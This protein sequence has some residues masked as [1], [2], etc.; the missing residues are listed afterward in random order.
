MNIL[1][2]I[3]TNNLYAISLYSRQIAGTIVLFIIA[4]YLSIYDYGLFTS[5]KSIITFCFMFANMEYSNYI[6]VSSQAN[7]KEV[8]LKIA[9]FLVNAIL[10]GFFIAFF[11]YFFKLENHLLFTLIIIRTFFDSIFFGLILPYFQATK[12][13]NN[14]AKINIIYSFCISLIAIISYIFKLSLVKFLLLNIGLGII[15]FIQCSYFAK[16]NYLLVFTYIKRFIRMIDKSIYG[17]IGSTISDY[18]YAQTSSLYV[19]T[20]LPKEQAALYFSANTIA[21]MVGLLS[22]AQTQKMLP[23]L[24]KSDIEN[25]KKILKK[26]LV[27][28]GAILSFILL[29]ITLF[30][31]LILKLLYGQDY[32]TNAYPILLIYFIAN[33]FIANGAIFGIYLTAINKQ[34]IKIKL[35]LETTIVTILGLIALHKFGVYGAV[36]ALL[37][38]AIYVSTR[39]T[40]YSLRF[41][42]NGECYEKQI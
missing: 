1:K 26:N 9:L 34:Y 7:I 17:Y 31:K 27:V 4:R 10:I 35:K 20:F 38:S 18:L 6:L 22:A 5:Y 14:I 37:I 16:I 40:M 36:T 23:D 12:T 29:L 3:L 8:K 42:K 2:N 41:I 21:M 11:S 33:I 28:V 15:N 39:F 30:G 32:Y 13:F 19:A 25:I 24:I